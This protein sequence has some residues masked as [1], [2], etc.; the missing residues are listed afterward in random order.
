M[1]VV[2][3]P[4]ARHRRVRIGQ[5]PVDQRDRPRRGRRHR[6]RSA[7]RRAASPSADCPSSR[8]DAA[9]WRSRRPRRNGAAARAAGP[10]SR[11]NRR[12]PPPRPGNLSLPMVGRHTSFSPVRAQASSPLSPST[13]ILATSSRLPPT[14]AI[15]ASGVLARAR[16]HPFGA[17]AGLAEAAA[18]ED[19]PVAPRRRAARTARRAPASPIPLRALRRTEAG[20]KSHTR[21]RTS[22]VHPASTR[23]ITLSVISSNSLPVAQAMGRGKGRCRE[24]CMG[25]RRYPRTSSNSSGGRA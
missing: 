14:S 21:S 1:R 15:R 8:P 18:G 3:R 9:I 4:P 5:Q 2:E 10:G 12:S 24:D 11:P 22:A 23:I 6:A 20:S 16:Q 13:I 19:Q 7:R 25:W 17:G